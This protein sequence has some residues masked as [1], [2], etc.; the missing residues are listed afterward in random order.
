MKLGL[1]HYTEFVAL[2]IALFSYQKFKGTYMVWFIP[3]LALT[4]LTEFINNILFTS[5]GIH[6]AWSYNFSGIIQVSFYTYIFINLAETKKHKQLLLVSH[7]MYTGFFC[8]YLTVTQHWRAFSQDAALFGFIEMVL[9][10]CGFFYQCLREDYD[11]ANQK[12]KTGL[13]ITAGVLIFYSG[14]SICFSLYDYI[15]KY[16]LRLNGRRLYGIIPQYLCII[17]YGCLSISFILWKK[18]VKK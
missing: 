3:F 2:I 12:Y 16:D 5:Y 11:I 8:I 6:T 13:W 17:L 15:V 9:F 14:V 1:H 18:P 4:F 10:S 7:L